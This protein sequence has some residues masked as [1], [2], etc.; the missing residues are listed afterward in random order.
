MHGSD[1]DNGR[2]GTLLSCQATCHLAG[3]S[4]AA[5]RATRKHGTHPAS[6]TTHTCENDLFMCSSTSMMAAMLPQLWE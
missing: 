2:R 4:S 1:N 6:S 5:A 3:A